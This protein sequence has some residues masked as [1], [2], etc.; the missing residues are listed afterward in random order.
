MF[1]FDRGLLN[2]K[3][4]SVV[5]ILIIKLFLFDCK[6]EIK[7]SYLVKLL[8]FDVIILKLCL[9]KVGEIKVLLKEQRRIKADLIL[10]IFLTVPVTVLVTVPFII[11]GLIHI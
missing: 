8:K 3:I 6:K 10:K 4:E 1:L 7:K 2:L 9:V 11:V 5:K